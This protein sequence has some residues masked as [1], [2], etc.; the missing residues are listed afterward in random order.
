MK[1]RLKLKNGKRNVTIEVKVRVSTLFGLMKEREAILMYNQ[2]I[3]KEYLKAGYY[4]TGMEDVDHE[5]TNREIHIQG[6]GI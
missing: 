4:I 5:K 3:V 2:E 1:L 6:H